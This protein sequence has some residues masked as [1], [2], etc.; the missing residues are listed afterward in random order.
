[1]KRCDFKK[2]SEISGILYDLWVKKEELFI[3][4]RLGLSDRS[5]FDHLDGLGGGLGA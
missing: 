4:I 2:L 3:Y 1:M 5:A